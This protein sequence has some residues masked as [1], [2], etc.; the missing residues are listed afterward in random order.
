MSQY[1]IRMEPG[2][3][4]VEAPGRALWVTQ[5]G[6]ERITGVARGDSSGDAGTPGATGPQGP[7]GP[8][9]AIGPQGPKGDTG[10]VGP[11]GQN[12]AQG[13]Q[14]IQGPAGNDGAAGAQGIQGPPGN[15]GAQGPQGIQ[16]DVGP[17]G[18]AGD[19]L[20][21]AQVIDTLYPVGSLYTS[22][23]STNPATLL[24]RGTWEAYA[25][26]R[27]LVGVDTADA[28]WDTGGE[29]RGAKTVA[30]TGTVSQPTFAGNAITDVINHTH[31]VNITDAGHVHTQRYHAA[32]TGGLSGP[33]TAPDTSSNTPTNYGLTTASATTGI[34][35]TTSNPAGGV[36]AITPTGTVSQPTFTGNATAVIQPSI[37]VY[38]WRRTA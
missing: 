26:G 21:L 32:T 3:I 2:H 13:P 28:D 24:S 1:T 6:L 31:P 29:T 16:G 10:D 9:G 12:G 8:Q 27:A 19:G 30:S 18:P 4:A 14:G 37:T 36:A 34:T 20:T 22:T 25:A 23:L 15:D 7:A 11:A 38:V 5:A 33:V 17:Q 35:A